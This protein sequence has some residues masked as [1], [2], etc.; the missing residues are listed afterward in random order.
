MRRPRG[1][2][3]VDERP[4]PAVALV[5]PVG[6]EVFEVYVLERLE[7]LF[8]L[9]QPLDRDA[10]SRHEG[11]TVSVVHASGWRTTTGPA[12]GPVR[13]AS[14]PALG[15]PSRG[16]VCVALGQVVALAALVGSHARGRAPAP[17]RVP[18]LA[19]HARPRVVPIR[20]RPADLGIPRQLTQEEPTD[21]SLRRAPCGRLLRFRAAGA[22]QSDW[23][24]T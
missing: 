2:Q 22:G 15:C 14:Y 7:R 11:G 9:A 18:G 5:V 13:S 24:P 21:W 17:A 12:P 1:D 19:S 20:R 10:L 3:I 6:V 8:V 23:R 4:H 16:V